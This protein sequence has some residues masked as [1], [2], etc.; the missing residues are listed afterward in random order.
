M[1]SVCKP[2]RMLPNL[3]YTFIAVSDARAADAAVIR[4]KGTCRRA[5]R[6]YTVPVVH[7]L[8]YSSNISMQCVVFLPIFLAQ[9]TN[10]F[11]LC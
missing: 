4:L 1:R 7:L 5:L 2:E 9:A 3:V 6:S 8:A 11:C 10:E